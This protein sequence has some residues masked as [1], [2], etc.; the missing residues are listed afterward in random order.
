LTCWK[1]GH[2]LNEEPLIIWET[3]NHF[4]K[5]HYEANLVHAPQKISSRKGAPTGA[6][7]VVPVE[8]ETLRKKVGLLS[9]KVEKYFK[10]ICTDSSIHISRD[11]ITFTSLVLR[12]NPHNRLK[13]RDLRILRPLIGWKGQDCPSSL[14]IER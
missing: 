7:G 3:Q 6:K 12:A 10:G 1:V 14:H 11:S 9:K 8:L 4:S 5:H 2:E 13:A